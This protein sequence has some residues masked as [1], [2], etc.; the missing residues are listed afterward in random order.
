MFLT[1]EKLKNIRFSNVKG[2]VT[3]S[4]VYSAP[5]GEVAT[6]DNRISIT[7]TYSDRN[8]NTKTTFDPSEYIKVTLNIQFDPTAPSGRYMVED[9]LPAS[10]KHVYSRNVDVEWGSDTWGMWYPHE[11]SGQK[12]SFCIYHRND[13]KSPVK[14]ISYFAR[15]NNYGEYTAD[16]ASVY[17][18]EGNVI[19]YAH[20]E[21]IIIK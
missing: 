12:V 18:L 6:I 4:A 20:R 13:D 7:R 5:I 1:A 10:L 16:Y 2:K 3:V 19:N 8:G 14:T 9:Y 15:V 17:N 21:Q 11:I